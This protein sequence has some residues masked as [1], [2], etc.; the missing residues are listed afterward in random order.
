MSIFDT[1]GRLMKKPAPGLL[2]LE[3]AEVD[4]QAALDAATERLAA[5][6]A[7][8][9]DAILS[10]DDARTAHRAALQ[11][12]RDDIEDG[13]AALAAIQARLSQEREV[14]AE[15][16]RVAAYNTALA[17]RD[18]VAALILE[19][20][21]QLAGG[22]VDLIR[23]SA[24]ADLAIEAANDDLPAGAEPLDKAEWLAR[25]MP[26]TPR[27][28]ISEKKVQLWCRPDTKYP[29][30]IQ[31]GIKEGRNGRGISKTSGLPFDRHTFIERRWER[32]RY[33]E[34]G[35]KLSG[36][37]LPGLVGGEP[38]FWESSPW[39]TAET[40]LQKIKQ[41]EALR[42]AHRAAPPEPP[43]IE[44]EYQLVDEPPAEAAE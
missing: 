31:V 44:V 29:T 1:I 24:E 25:S 15:A 8:R 34:L 7:N 22:L 42:R 16:A 33:V 32:A 14:A 9:T 23:L 20:Y 12:A 11:T 30:D 35:E 36:L 21:P 10:G 37:D 18:E 28:L 43:E 40:I 39:S 41:H 17:K 4:A 38:A 6:E 3:K 19:K 2:A 5:L 27:K 26:G 13:R